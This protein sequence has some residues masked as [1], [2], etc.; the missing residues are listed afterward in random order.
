MVIREKRIAM[1]MSQQKL[2]HMC[3]LS[4][5]AISRYEAGK[6]MPNIETAFKL[7]KALH[8]TVDDLVEKNQA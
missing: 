8:C 7:A 2:A 3:G 1:G 6:R 5:A 4:H